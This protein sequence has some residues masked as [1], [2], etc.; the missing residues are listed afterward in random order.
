MTWTL[1]NRP[2]D[3]RAGRRRP[4]SRRAPPAGRPRGPSAGGPS[5]ATTSGVVAPSGPAR[6]DHDRRGRGGPA[7]TAAASTSSPCTDSSRF[8]DPLVRARPELQ[9]EHRRGEQEQEREV[10]PIATGHGCRMIAVRERGPEAVLVVGSALHHARGSSRTPSS[11]RPDKREQ[12]GQERQRRDHRDR[13]DDQAADPEAAHERQRHEEQET[14]GRSRPRCR[15]RRR[16]GRPW[17]SSSR[18][19]RRASCAVR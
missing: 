2:S 17:S 7:P 1:R 6:V 3:R 12:H 18:S 13:R 5:A 10:V 15:R 14:R 4:G 9:R 19:P 11:L 16:P 8:R